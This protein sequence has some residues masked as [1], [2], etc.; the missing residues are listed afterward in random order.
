[1]PW[2]QIWSSLQP[3]VPSLETAGLFV[4]VVVTYFLTQRL[5]GVR[6]VPA[7]VARDMFIVALLWICATGL[8]LLEPNYHWMQ[9]GANWVV[10]L[11]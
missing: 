1:M 6:N 5:T 3:V 4:L 2:D 9:R 8:V 10:N 11:W 7:I